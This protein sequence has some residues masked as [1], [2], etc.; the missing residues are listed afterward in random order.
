MIEKNYLKTKPQCKVKFAL[1]AEQ[2]QGA[3]KVY[4]VGD[5]NDWNETATPM[6]K[7]KTG[8]YASTLSLDNDQQYQ[9]RYLVDGHWLNDDA[10]DSYQQSP[11]SPDHNCVINI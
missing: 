6:R 3:K 5:F 7:Q 10:A 1:T 2:L 9:F 11:I 8:V 4:L